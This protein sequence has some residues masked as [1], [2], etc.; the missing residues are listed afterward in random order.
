[1]VIIMMNFFTGLGDFF[2]ILLFQ[3]RVFDQF[4]YLAL[5]CL[6]VIIVASVAKQL[7]LGRSL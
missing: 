2:L 6:S 7:I 3:N 1:M 4:H 5:A